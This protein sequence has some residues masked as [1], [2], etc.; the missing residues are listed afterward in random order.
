MRRAHPAARGGIYVAVLAIGMLVSILGISGLIAARASGREVEYTRDTEEAEQLS[1]AALELGRLAI[2]GN[3]T[4]RKTLSNGA[5][6]SSLALGRGRLAWR[7]VDETDGDLANNESDPVRLYGQ[8]VCG[9]SVRVT[10]VL[11][12]ARRVPLPALGMALHTEGQLHVR[13][14]QVL[15]AL[16][17]T[18]STNTTLRNDGT[19]TGNAEALT[20]TGTG[21]V[22]GTTTLLAPAK[23]FP[24]SSVVTLYTNRGTAISP[25]TSIS[26]QLLSPAANPWG[27]PHPDGV[28]VINT[29]S[30][31]TIANSR[32]VGTLVINC[33]GKLVTIQNSVL[34]QPARADYPALI[35]NGNAD[36]R[37]SSASSTLSEAAAGRNF[38]PAGTPYLGASDTDLTDTYPNEIQGLVHV[39]GTLVT[40][41]TPRIRGLALV[42]SSATLDAVD[43]S[44]TVEIIYDPNLY[45]NPP[46]GYCTREMAPQAGSRRREP[47]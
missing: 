36:F 44:G 26:G 11:L 9:G 46:D 13:S 3:A 33:P 7:V 38:N 29:A 37:Y 28:Y 1:Q 14:G 5:W 19:I 17:A 35:I 43:V 41:S 24:D 22:T 45:T 30:N 39:T 15:T 25:G 40:T 18:A 12:T 32:I 23:A 8:G 34:I 2:D 16:N 10:S 27:S 21:T 47:Q 4:W 6:S 42:Q 20:S 31:L